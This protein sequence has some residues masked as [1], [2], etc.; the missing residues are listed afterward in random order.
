MSKLKQIKF[1][2]AEAHCV[3]S[4]LLDLIVW[5]EDAGQQTCSSCASALKK[6]QGALK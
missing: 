4:G 1:T 6:V 3:E 5:T 2:E